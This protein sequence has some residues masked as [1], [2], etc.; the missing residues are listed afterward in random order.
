M[1]IGLSSYSLNANIR[2]GKMDVLDAMRFA[3]EKGAEHFEIVPIGYAFYNA[4]S[5]EFNEKMIEDVKALSKELDLPLSN[6]AVGADLI[7]ED[8]SLQDAA[9]ERT[10]R[11]VDVAAK[12]GIKFMR[13][14]ISFRRFDCPALAFEKY[15]PIAVRAVQKIADYAAGYGIT[16][17]TENHGFFFNGSDRMIRLVNAV[18]RPNFGLLLDCGNFICVDE[19][20]LIAVKKCAPIAKMV[21]LK[22][23]Y[24]RRT[25][26]NGRFASLVDAGIGHWFSSGSGEYMLRGSIVGQGDLDLWSTVAELKKVGYDGYVSIEF[27][28]M[29][30]CESGSEIGM[31]TA[32]HMLATL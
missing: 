22:D 28:G 20:P 14:D 29:E 10:C 16:T 13:H 18:D 15:L 32:K 25:E 21:H 19:D 7:D 3:K 8:P 9:I 2:S 27:E 12:L 17:T 31:L 11:Q 26:L 24:I 1:K 6:L 23:F 30:N 4:E 5:G